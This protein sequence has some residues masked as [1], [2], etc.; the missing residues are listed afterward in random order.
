VNLSSLGVGKPSLVCLSPIPE[1]S[2]FVDR[3]T[4]L[5]TLWEEL[6]LEK[7]ELLIAASKVSTCT[8]N[9]R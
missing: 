7:E 2:P 4:P 5:E 9:D 6:G 8:V 1:H 3:G